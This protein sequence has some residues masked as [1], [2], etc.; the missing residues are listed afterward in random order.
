MILQNI[1][2]CVVIV[3]NQYIKLCNEQ[4][5]HLFVNMILDINGSQTSI[6]S[7]KRSPR[8]PSKLFKNFKYQITSY[9][10]GYQVK[11]E[12]EECGSLEVQNELL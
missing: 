10:R 3:D 5:L 8:T 7:P 12:S 1:E 6:D 2:D 9:I 4:F 11:D